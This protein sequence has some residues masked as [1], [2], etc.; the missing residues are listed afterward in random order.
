[1]SQQLLKKFLPWGYLGGSITY[2]FANSYKD[3][4]YMATQFKNNKIDD[5]HKKYHNIDSELSAAQYGATKYLG[6]YVPLSLIWPLAA[7]L[8]VIPYMVTSSKNE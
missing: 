1:M 6:L 2:I 8:N 4:K 3:A 7:P 5:F